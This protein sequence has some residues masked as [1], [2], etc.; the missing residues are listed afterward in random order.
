MPPRLVVLEGGI[1]LDSGPECSFVELGLELKGL[2]FIL[3]I[4]ELEPQANSG[5][6][7]RPV[8]RS[9]NALLSLRPIGRRH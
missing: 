5:K 6:I 1:G 3:A 9:N 2:G 4:Y 7:N 8:K